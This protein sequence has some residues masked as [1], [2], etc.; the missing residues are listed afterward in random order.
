[1]RALVAALF[2]DFDETIGAVNAD[3]WPEDMAR[4]GF[5]L[6]H[7]TWDVDALVQALER[8][9]HGVGGLQALERFATRA[10]YDHGGARVIA[11]QQIVHI[12]PA[13]PGAGLTP[14]M[15]GWLL[16]AR[17]VIRPSSRGAYF[18]EHLHRL[19]RGLSPPTSALSLEFGSPNTSWRDVDAL[20]I[21]GSDE[22]IGAL[23]D[24][25]G[26]GHHRGRPTVLAYGHRVSFAVIVDDGTDAI[27]EQARLLALDVVLWHQMG[28]FSARAVMF[29]GTS[30]RL[31]RFAE[32][33][34]EAI[35]AR[36]RE[37]GATQL[38]E[39]RLAQRAQARGVAEF[40]GNFWGDG[41]GW[42]Q[43][44]SS[45]WRGDQLAPHAVTIHAVQSP[46]ELRHMI[47]VPARNL[48]GAALYVAGGPTPRRAWAEA[49]ARLGVTR[50]CAP[51]QLQAPPASWLHDGWPNVLDLVRV[52]TIDPE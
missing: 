50:V 27:F 33:L 7:Q 45:P 14:V 48:Q 40:M 29:C 35:E 2:D 36:E 46:D 17:Q 10:E 42:V 41:V 4:A 34:G 22:T 5:A 1:M 25:I 21:S 43:R 32:A 24:F 20:V 31:E 39:A 47:K 28:C 49:L 9:L 19:W 26:A 23:I 16:G 15:F 52:C 30:E 38:D 12:W 44:S 11:P 18:A 3:G 8:E 37:L 51:G 6:H 13:L